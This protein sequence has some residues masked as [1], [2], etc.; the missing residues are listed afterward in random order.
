MSALPPIADMDQ[1]AVNVRFVPEADILNACSGLDYVGNPPV[2]WPKRCCAPLTAI[3]RRE[4]SK[5]LEAREEKIGAAFQSG[6]GRQAGDF[7]SDRTLR[8]CEFKRA[9]LSA[10]DWI[11][12][13]A[14]LVKIPIV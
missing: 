7:L 14:E 10:D 2:H 13:V 12:F 5:R 4:V 3:K 6:E 1:S 9:V 11:V 8:N